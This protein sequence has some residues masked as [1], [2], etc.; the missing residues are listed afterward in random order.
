MGPELIGLLGACLCL[1]QLLQ[2]PIQQSTVSMSPCKRESP[3]H[4]VGAQ[5]LFVGLSSGFLILK[6]RQFLFH[7]HPQNR[8]TLLLHRVLREACRRGQGRR[9]GP[10]GPLGG[11]ED[12]LWSG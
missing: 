11:R 9:A 4:M 12:S 3:L 7:S 8:R 1:W 6:H 10:G 5:L 2:G